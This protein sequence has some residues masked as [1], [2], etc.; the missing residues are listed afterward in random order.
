MENSRKLSKVSY[1]LESLKKRQ[2]GGLDRAEVRNIFFF[3]KVLLIC[4][5][6]L[7]YNCAIIF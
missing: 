2:D 4:L 5:P 1:T 3:P 6:R 7:S